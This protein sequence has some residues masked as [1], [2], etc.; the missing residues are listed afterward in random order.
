MQDLV[1][2]SGQAG[3]KEASVTISFDNRDKSKS[4]TGFLEYDTINVSRII[5]VTH[6]F[7]TSERHEQVLRERY[8][9]HGSEREA[10]VQEHRSQY[11]P[12]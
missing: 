9:E 6:L 7:L 4:P 1:Y 10:N 12:A 2:K 8:H 11:R 3:I 5:A